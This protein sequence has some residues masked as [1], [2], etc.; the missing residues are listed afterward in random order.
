MV[1]DDHTS[2]GGWRVDQP[3]PPPTPALIPALA[4]AGRVATDRP[5][6]DKG[7]GGRGERR[8]HIR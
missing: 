1:G 6:A 5:L 2:L 7:G 3:P 8:A 4:E